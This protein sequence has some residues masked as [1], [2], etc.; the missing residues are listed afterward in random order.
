MTGYKDHWMRAVNSRD[1]TERDTVGDE[2]SGMS[3]SKE[4]I[5]AD[6]LESQLPV[7]CD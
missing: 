5:Y 3:Y 2:V 1:V 4:L 7:S 6:S